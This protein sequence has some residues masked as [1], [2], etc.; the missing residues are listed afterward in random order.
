MAKVSGGASG[1]V[2]VEYKETRISEIIDRFWSG[3]MEYKE[4]GFSDLVDSAVDSTENFKGI[5]SLKDPQ[6]INRRPD[7]LVGPSLELNLGGQLSK[8]ALDDKKEQ[9][10]VTIDE[11]SQVLSHNSEETTSCQLNV[12]ENIG[13]EDFEVLNMVGEGIFGK[14]F[15]VQRKGTSQIYAMKIVNKD[16]VLHSYVEAKKDILTKIVHPFIVQHRYFFQVLFHV[17]LNPYYDWFYN[18]ILLI[19]NSILVLQSCILVV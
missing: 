7:N 8:L 6:T 17:S 3:E 18:T 12:T 15:Q 11:R 16:L 1:A 10:G 4:T 5:R 2:K 9:L 19:V 13:V 14:V